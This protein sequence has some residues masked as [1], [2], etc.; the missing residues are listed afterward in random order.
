MSV[1]LMMEKSSS[2]PACPD[3]FIWS[4][5]D[6]ELGQARLPPLISRYIIEDMPYYSYSSPRFEDSLPYMALKI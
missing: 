3:C 5:T 4:Q 1:L 6:E 2:V